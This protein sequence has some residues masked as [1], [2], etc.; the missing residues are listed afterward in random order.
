[1][2]PHNPVLIVEDDRDCREMLATLVEALGYSVVTACQG[3]EAL[4]LTRAY[5]PCLILLDLMMPVMDGEEFR[6]Q[7]LG[8]PTINDIPVII[9]SAKHSAGSIA[10]RLQAF[11]A[12]GKP[13]DV[14]EVR[15]KV[16]Q[17]CAP[18]N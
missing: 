6:A 12:I 4:E 15:A 14:N 11:A 16:A 7:Q 10:Q 8:D 9:V 17:A 1:M 5:H 13:I 3:A 2:R 18:P